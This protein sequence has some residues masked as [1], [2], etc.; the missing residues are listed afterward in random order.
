MSRG[1]LLVGDKFTSI[2]KIQDVKENLVKTEAVQNMGDIRSKV[3]SVISKTLGYYL[4][5]EMCRVKVR[6]VRIKR[7]QNRKY[8]I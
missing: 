8:Q 7:E 6:L 5:P 4:Y 1:G 2:K 3:G